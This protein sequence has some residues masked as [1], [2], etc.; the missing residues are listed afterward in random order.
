MEAYYIHAHAHATGKSCAFCFCP[1]TRRKHKT[2]S[3]IF[4]VVVYNF[5]LASTV[6]GFIAHATVF[7]GC[8]K[9][10]F[11]LT[12]TSSPAY[13]LLLLQQLITTAYINHQVCVFL[14]Y[15]KGSVS[16]II[17]TFRFQGSCSFDSL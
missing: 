16:V 2:K 11:Q 13:F 15:F 7:I 14:F 17:S 12:D 3:E 6:R 1:V 5:N 9:G 8:I 10:N 4:D